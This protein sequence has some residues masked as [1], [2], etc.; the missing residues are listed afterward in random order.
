MRITHVRVAI[1]HPLGH[2]LRDAGAFLDPHGGSTPQI[3]HL[4]GLAQHRVGVGGEAEQTVDRVADLGIAEHLHQLDGLLHLR[5]E[6]VVGERQFGWG[7][8]RGSDRGDVVRAHQDWSVGI[9]AD[10]HRSGRLTLVAERVHIADDR[11]GQFLTGLLQDVDR[12][13]VGHLMHGRGERNVGTGHLGDARAPHT[14]GDDHVVG[15]DRAAIGDDGLDA[16][17]TGRRFGEQIQ[18][19]GVGEHGQHTVGDG[20]VAHL[21]AGGER[22]DHGDA[23]RVVAPEEDL[24]VDERHQLLDLG[25][26][27]QASIDTPRLG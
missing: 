13:D 26:G 25:G 22:V 10:L 5:I 19:F 12:A 27:D 21:G 15:L 14:A 24:L 8:R 4:G 20:L 18:H 16:R 9:A 17:P 6:I 2:Q 1:C 23:G 7:Q 11:E 3:A